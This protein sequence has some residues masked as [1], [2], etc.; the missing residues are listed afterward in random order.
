MKGWVA[1]TRRVPHIHVPNIKAT[2]TIALIAA[3][4]AQYA[5]VYHHQLLIFHVPQWKFDAYFKQNVSYSVVWHA[6]QKCTPVYGL[7]EYLWYSF[8]PR[9]FL[10]LIRCRIYFCH[11]IFGIRQIDPPHR[12][13]VKRERVQ[14]EKCPHLIHVSSSRKINCLKRW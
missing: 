9:S 2:T 3:A 13:E 4:T 14:R 11:S 8:L 1:G 5:R 10:F 6:I 12:W 7:I